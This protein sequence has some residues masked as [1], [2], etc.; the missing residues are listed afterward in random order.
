[1]KGKP[2]ERGGGGGGGGGKIVP[3]L[4][5]RLR[6]SKHS[7]SMIRQLILRALQSIK[8]RPAYFT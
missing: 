5:L 7:L 1:M 6:K 8:F 3:K 4:R 2:T